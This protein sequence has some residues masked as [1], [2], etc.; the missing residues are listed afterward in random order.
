MVPLQLSAEVRRALE[1]GDGV[2]ALE[3]TLIAH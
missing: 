2:V 1:A 3:T